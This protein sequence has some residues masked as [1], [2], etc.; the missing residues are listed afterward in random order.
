MSK[1]RRRALKTKTKPLVCFLDVQQTWGTGTLIPLILPYLLQHTSIKFLVLLCSS[2]FFDPFT[3][4]PGSLWPEQRFCPQWVQRGTLRMCRI[5]HSILFCVMPTWQVAA[6]NIIMS[7]VPKFVCFLG[8]FSKF[9]GNKH[10]IW[11]MIYCP[12]TF[13]ILL[14]SY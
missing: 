3:E 13:N 7:T 11:G 10:N 9:K 8:C 4:L 5:C 6:W 14:Y 2:L 12:T 1:L